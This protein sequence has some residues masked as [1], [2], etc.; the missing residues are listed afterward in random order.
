M[1][2]APGAP[3]LVVVS[4]SEIRDASHT[5]PSPQSEPRR[6]EM[7]L[8]MR[9]LE[10]LEEAGGLP[11]AVPP[12]APEAL[13][14][15][16]DRA[17]AVCLPGGPDMHPVAYGAEP[18]PLLG[19]TFPELDLF[20]LALLRGADERGLPVLAICRGMQ[21][22]NVARGGSLHQ[23]LPDVAGHRVEHRQPKPGDEV[24]H[25]V[26]LDAVGRLR[27]LLGDGAVRVNSFHH[28]A[29]DR[30]GRGL[31]VAGRAA[32][33]TVEGVEGLEDRFVVG[34]QWHAESLT[35]RPEQ[36]A[37]F[38]ALVDAARAREPACAVSPAS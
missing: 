8:G 4:T 30:L 7:V 36:R 27:G 29:V 19:P 22:L 17:D 25:A 6:R 16:L 1:A 28:Q 3:P 34:V 13:E 14:A 2:P 31:A 10:A 26:A 38:Q 11:V 21:V 5:V 37:L 9:Y 18:H 35:A 32:D 33:G 12:L 20:E 23:H 24:T 15:L